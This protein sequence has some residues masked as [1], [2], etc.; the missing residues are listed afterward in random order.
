M[1]YIKIFYFGPIVNLGGSPRS[2]L[3]WMGWDIFPLSWNYTLKV[4]KKVAQEKR[5]NNSNT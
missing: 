4:T 1:R 2:S 3:F 5:M